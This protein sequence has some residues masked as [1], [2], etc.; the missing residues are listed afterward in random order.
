MEK[1]KPLFLILKKKYFDQIATGEKREEYR[2][3]KPHWVNR[4]EGR[5]YSH[6][7]F[8]NGYATDAPRIE[9]EYKGWYKKKL[10]HEFFDNKAVTVY[11][12]KLGKIINYKKLK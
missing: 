1:I 9:I 2:E 10:K 6:I 5:K 12:L 3:A 11:A 7:I 8:Q 4:I